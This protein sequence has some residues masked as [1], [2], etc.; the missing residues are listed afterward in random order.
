MTVFIHCQA[1]H[2]LA[3]DPSPVW[4]PWLNSKSREDTVALAA[5]RFLRN[6]GGVQ[7]GERFDFAVFSYLDS[8]P[9]KAD[10]SPAECLV[11]T[12]TSDRR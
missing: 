11:D 8:T 12:F 6:R 2:R 9:L 10:G 7:P 5:H 1:G 3:L 4:M